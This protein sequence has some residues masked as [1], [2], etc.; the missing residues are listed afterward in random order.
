MNSKMK[1][2]G[3]FVV[4]LNGS[5]EIEPGVKDLPP[6][7]FTHHIEVPS[8]VDCAEPSYDWEMYDYHWYRR[9]F[10]A[11]DNWKG[12]PAFLR[13]EQSMYGS[14]V[15]VNGNFAG[16][17]ISCYTS[18]EYRVDG[19]LRYGSTN[20][21][22]VKVGQRKNLPHES[23]VG[24][25]QE[26]ISFIPGI[27]GDVKLV[28][29]GRVRVK[30]VQTL[31]NLRESCLDVNIWVENLASD[32]QEVVLSGQ[33]SEKVTGDI[34][35]EDASTRLGLAPASE[36][37]ASLRI[38]MR[39]VKLWSPDSPFLYVFSATLN[40]PDGALIDE[41]R[42]VFG[43]REFSI[44]GPDFL[45]NGKKIFL[46]GSNIAFH[47]FL[48]DSDR[49]MLPWNRDWVRRLLVDIPKEHNFNFFRAHLG[50]MYNRW[51]DIADEGGIMLQDEWQFWGTTGT[52][53]QIT[54]EFTDW[55]ED[56]WNHPSIVIW[57]AL[58]ESSDDVVQH[59][60]IPGMKKLDPTRPWESHDFSEDHPYIYSLGPVLVNR[61]FGYTRS[62]DEIEDSRRPSQVNEYLWWWLDKEFR[63]SGLTKKVVSRWLGEDYSTDELIEHQ[64]F[65]A[66]ELT[67]LF[68]RLRVKCIQPFVYLS[69]NEG[70]TSHWFVGDPA[71][72][73]TKPVMAALKN[74]FEPFGVSIEL[75]DRHFF[76]SEKRNIAVYLFNDY[77]GSVTG[78][79]TYGMKNSKGD[80]LTSKEIDA[81]VDGSTHKV[82]HLVFRFP[83]RAG[84]YNMVAELVN[85]TTGLKAVSTKTTHVYDEPQIPD[86]GSPI[87]V[88]VIDGDGE[89]TDFLSSPGFNA[90]DVE[91][92]FDASLD[93]LV[94]AGGSGSRLA[95]EAVSGRVSQWVEDGHVLILVEPEA[96]VTDH[97]TMTLP[98][99][100]RL[101]VERREDPAEGGYDSYLIPADV[102]HPVWRGIRKI[103]L[104]MFN[105]GYGGEVV[106]Q[107]N[108]KIDGEHEVLARSGL[109]LSRPAALEVR[110]GNG[111]VVVTSVEVGGRLVA[112]EGCYD[113]LYA[114]R[115][116]PV[117]QTYLLNLI[118]FYSAGKGKASLSGRCNEY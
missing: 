26:S 104:Q 80:W 37:K 61:K 117:V 78:R 65:L 108:L 59:E 114:L 113:T 89:I 67:E 47:R 91:G 4:N 85:S 48:S 17:S 94:V 74:A 60:I 10:F 109:N 84:D 115:P 51:Y 82:L 86:R 25:D 98:G 15:W 107:Y 27:W 69:A 42:V 2:D 46:K 44:E 58:N 21:V 6:V 13:L 11:E 99:G 12:S 7:K 90:I 79:L 112:R 24:R 34:S 22:V 43:M 106:P 33:V 75:W 116:D 3:R 64:S 77:P 30:L 55:L 38:P 9:T 39:N 83:D 110:A 50:H 66:S 41:E 20:E 92:E 28:Y 57:D 32:F 95:Y 23:A 96:D 97:V 36:S 76:R 118:A 16:G 62:L 14:E 49:H 35:P 45:L 105:G 88:G 111:V 8:L 5:W 53:E 73:R 19:L 81:A 101:D 40:E 1:I 71:G 100:V 68:R 52:K 72:L 31:P 29:T 56:N 63:P 103:D 18:Q 102:I 87:R 54:R 93:L 70:P